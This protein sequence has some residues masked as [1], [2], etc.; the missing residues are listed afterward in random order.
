MPKTKMMTTWRRSSRQQDITAG[1]VPEPVSGRHKPVSGN[2]SPLHLWLL[3]LV[4]LWVVA[5]Q[6]AGPRLAYFYKPPLDGTAASFIAHHFDLI[7][8]THADES[9]RDQLRRVG[10]TG[11][12]LQN[13]AA[14]EAEG[15]GPYASHKDPCD[16]SYDPYQRTAVDEPGMFCREV[17][18]HEDWFLHNRLG[19]R[20]YDRTRSANGVWRTTYDMNPGSRGWQQFLIDRMRFYR[21]LGYDGFFLD[22]VAL[23]RYGLLHEPDNHGGLAE[24]ANDA[25]WRKAVLSYLSALR[26]AFP[27]VPLWANLV[28]DPGTPGNWMP[29]LQYLDGMMVEDFATGWKDY[30][31]PS[32]EVQQQME[33]IRQALAAG[34]DVIAV[35]QGLQKDQKRL[36][37]ALACYWLLNNEHL[38]FRYADAFDW[39]YR[40]IWWYPQY[41]FD[42]G[43][44]LGPLHFNDSNWSRRFKSGMIRVDFATRSAHM[45]RAAGFAPH[46]DEA[47][48]TMRAHPSTR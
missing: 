24:Y 45:P 40:K 31:L 8:L 7:I 29:Y 10:Y 34:K 35:A 13:L 46:N 41:R 16:L 44:P 14:N 9:Y 48:N 2:A 38:Y 33:N 18:P 3:P 26:R 25:D 43:A 4:L 1:G 37:M 47:A 15:P 39:A 27:D 22:N 42:P 12:I 19:Q 20:L 30:P 28:H 36:E 23:S 17:H 5:A 21:H 6:A 11:M 32:Q